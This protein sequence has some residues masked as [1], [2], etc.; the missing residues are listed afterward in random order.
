MKKAILLT[1][2]LLAAPAMAA[3]ELSCSVDVN[4]V[5]TIS[6]D[7]NE[8]ELVRAFA[9]DVEIDAN[10]TITGVVSVNPKFWV[11]PGTIIIDPNSEGDPCDYGTPVAPA[12]DPGSMGGLP[13]TA[14]TVELGS[15]YEANDVNL[16][17]DANGIVIQ[18]QLD[19]TGEGEVSVT[20]NE[21]RGRIVL[22]DTNSVDANCVCTFES[23]GPACWNFLTQCHGDADGNGSVSI[24]DL[25]LFIAAWGQV[26]PAVGYDPC[27]DFDKNGSVS[28]GD[29]SEFIARWGTSPPPDCT[30]GGTWPP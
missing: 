27:A 7:S 3:V 28:I 29:L 2:L 24:G 18:L 11:Y 23:S 13:G 25:S 16:T 14:C 22:E 21:T 19:V 26:Y 4:G 20:T 1:M 12:N 9:L 6:Y 8:V 5:L 17:P 10:A 15:L 30:P